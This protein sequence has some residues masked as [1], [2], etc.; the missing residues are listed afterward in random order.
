MSTSQEGTPVEPSLDRRC[1]AAALF[2]FPGP[3][4]DPFDRVAGLP[5]LTRALL[6]LEKAGFER[7]RVVAPREVAARFAELRAGRAFKAEIE[8]MECAT[9]DEAPGKLALASGELIVCTSV[10]EVVDPAILRALGAA[11]LETALAVAARGAGRWVGPF[12]ASTSG[13]AALAGA[14]PRDAIQKLADESKIVPL[15]VGTAWH[16]RADGPEGRRQAVHALFE[17]CRKPVDGLVSR[18]L[19]RHISIFISKR[20]VSTRVTPN[21]MSL[22]TFLLGVAGAIS[23]A[24]GG[25]WWFLLGAWL[26]QWNSILDGVDGELARVRFQQSKLGQWVDTVSDDVS[27][28]AFYGGLAIGAS[29]LE[30]GALLAMCGWVAI[31]ATLLTVSQYYVEL[32][33]LGSGDFYALGWSSKKARP[34]FGARIVSLFERVLKKDFF[35]FLFLGMAVVGLLPYALVIAAFGACIALGAATARNIGRLL[36]RRSPQQVKLEPTAA[37]RP[38]RPKAPEPRA[39]ADA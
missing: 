12:L 27:N 3:G 34:S 25:Y 14:D 33:S 21:Q 28:M 37:C 24:R 18:H 23:V 11:S 8:V 1:H 2:A 26:F 36:R 30:H 10:E 16:A 15:D 19:N 9:R 35:I 31:G 32:A 4:F 13:L 20:L 5:L 29:R 39:S 38:S 22:V 7:V 6:T 17:A